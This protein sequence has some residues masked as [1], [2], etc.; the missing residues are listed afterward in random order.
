[1]RL[2]FLFIVAALW[3]ATQAPVILPSHWQGD[4][5]IIAVPGPGCLMAMP[6]DTGTEACNFSGNAW[7]AQLPRFGDQGVAASV[8]GRWYEWESGG[9]RVGRAD[10]PPYAIIWLPWVANE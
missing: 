5:L 10:V 8:P 6:G 4:V 3:L 2:L 9:V 1:M 7:E